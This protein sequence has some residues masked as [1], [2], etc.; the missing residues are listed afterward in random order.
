[1][2]LRMVSSAS[3][4]FSSEWWLLVLILMAIYRSLDHRQLQMVSQSKVTQEVEATGEDLWQAI[5]WS[6]SRNQ[7]WSRFDI[8]HGGLGQDGLDRNGQG[9]NMVSFL[10]RLAVMG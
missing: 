8:F 2:R 5:L 3:A 6:W 10:L 1:M 4:A 9:G 7:V